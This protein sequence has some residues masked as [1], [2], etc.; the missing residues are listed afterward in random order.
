MGSVASKWKVEDSEPKKLANFLIALAQ[1]CRGARV[2]AIKPWLEILAEES[3]N[4]VNATDSERRNIDRY[5]SLGRR[6]PDFLA[7]QALHPLSCFGLSDPAFFLMY[8]GPDRR[9]QVLRDIAKILLPDHLL[10]GALIRTFTSDCHSVEYATV[11]PTMLRQSLGKSEVRSHCRWILLPKILESPNANGPYMENENVFGIDGKL[12]AVYENKYTGNRFFQ[13][14]KD[15][16]L[17]RS[18]DII[19]H[20]NEP[21]GFLEFSTIVN[22]DRRFTWKNTNPQRLAMKRGE[23]CCSAN[24]SFHLWDE[25]SIMPKWELGESEHMYAGAHYLCV[26]GEAKAS[27]IFLPC[28]EEGVVSPSFSVSDLLSTEQVTSLLTMNYFGSSWLEKYLKSLSKLAP[29]SRYVH[30]FRS[31]DAVAGASAVYE[32]LPNAD[33]DLNFSKGLHS[34]AWARAFQSNQ[35]NLNVSLPTSPSH[36]MMVGSHRTI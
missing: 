4:Y 28:R 29:D 11:I 17:R 36:S 27:A 13:F 35:L 12:T 31:L 15:A 26:I 25:S 19:T 14:G 9:V 24:T 16:A 21:C 20:T 30:Y 10:D 18:M 1:S 33:I 8:M 32:S 34:F 23:L 5:I 7:G 2:T 6:R 22:E 3:Q